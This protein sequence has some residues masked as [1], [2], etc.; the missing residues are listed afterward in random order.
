M[1]CH[2]IVEELKQDFLQGVQ[3]VAENHALGIQT[4]IN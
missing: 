1:L 3:I 4:D 2:L